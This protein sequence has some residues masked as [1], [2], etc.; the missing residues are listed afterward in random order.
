MLLH[1]EQDEHTLCGAS[2][3]STALAHCVTCTVCLGAMQPGLQLPAKVLNQWHQ[4]QRS[5]EKHMQEMEI[6]GR[7]DDNEQIREALRL[8]RPDCR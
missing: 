4:Q 1:Y 6:K 2:G 8:L 5:Y 7:N 3:P